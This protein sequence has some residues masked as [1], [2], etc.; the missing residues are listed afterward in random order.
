MLTGAVLFGVNVALL[1]RTAYRAYTEADHQFFPFACS[2]FSA[3]DAITL[4]TTL[5]LFLV[6]YLTTFMKY[7]FFGQLRLIEEEHLRE[8]GWMTASESLLAMTVFRNQFDAA[9]VVLFAVVLAVKAVHWVAKDRQEMMEQ[10]VRLPEYYHYRMTAC[11]ACL[12]I[13]DISGVVV[14]GW[15]LWVNGPSMALLLVSDFG[16]LLV[17]VLSMTVKYGVAVYEAS[18]RADN[19]AFELQVL[20]L[21]RSTFLYYFD[22]FIDMTKLAIYLI[23]FSTIIVFYGLPLHLFRELYM[24]V[25]SFVKK[26]QEVIKY[27]RA[28]ENMNARYP[29]ARQEDLE[30]VH[31]LCVVCREEM[32]VGEGPKGNKVLPCGHSFHF[33]CLRSWLERQQACPTCRASVIV[34][35]SSASASTTRAPAGTS[36]T[37]SRT[38]SQEQPDVKESIESLKKQLDELQ[39]NMNETSTLIRSMSASISTG[40]STGSVAES[41]RDITVDDPVATISDEHPDES[42]NN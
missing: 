9:V 36:T 7:L 23:F 34:T 20:N 35:R 3:T 10:S 6:F 13:I 19:D 39:K 42:D 25:M 33:K 2:F 26:C 40:A 17:S 29:D 5:T 32:R 41:P 21:D 12:A 38:A 15:W 14:C 16:I 30:R 4:L 8:Y 18:K 31:H 27:R 11:L 22:V 37:P 1:G 24:T 28:T